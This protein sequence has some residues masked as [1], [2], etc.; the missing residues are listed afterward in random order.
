MCRNVKTERL[1]L[2]REHLHQRP[3][4]HV[5]ANHRRCRRWRWRRAKK[6]VLPHRFCSF[7]PGRTCEH[8]IDLTA[9]CCTPKI[10]DRLVSERIKRATANQSFQYALVNATL[11]DALGKIGHRLKW[12]AL[13]RL[14][15]RV[16]TG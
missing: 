9:Q 7:R 13:P 15:Y 2:S 8:A 10:D 6:I 3:G 11:F 1:L 5:R 12:S 14:N 16:H 4:L